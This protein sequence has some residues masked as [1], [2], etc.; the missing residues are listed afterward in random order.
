[1]KLKMETTGD[2]RDYKGLLET[3]RDYTETVRDY[4][5]LWRLLETTRDY[6]DY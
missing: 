5:R 6:G 1:M 3:T 4:K 2:Y